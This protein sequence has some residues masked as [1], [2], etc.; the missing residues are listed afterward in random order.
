MVEKVIV[1]EF[2]DS[3]AYSYGG[4]IMKSKCRGTKY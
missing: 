2:L 4:S 3:G 1:K